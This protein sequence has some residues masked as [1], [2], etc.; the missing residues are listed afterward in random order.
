VSDRAGVRLDGVSPLA[1]VTLVL[2]ALSVGHDLD[3]LFNQPS[4]T[5][6]TEITVTAIL[7]Y[8]ALLGTLYLAVRR[9]PLA[10]LVATLMGL[11]VLVGFAA[12]HLAPHWSFLSDP[13]SKVQ[14]LNWLSWALVFVPMAAALALAITGIREMR[15]RPT[16]AASGAA[17][18]A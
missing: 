8:P 9:D 2:I 7:S 18:V 3:H 17:A 5:Y 1:R 4:R 6:S 16:T 14:G 12:V 13:Y 15:K 11:S 10:P